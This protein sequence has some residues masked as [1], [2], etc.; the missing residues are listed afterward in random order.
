LTPEKRLLRKTIDCYTKN[1]LIKFQTQA[2]Y[3]LE[4]EV[5]RNISTHF[6]SEIPTSTSSI[7]KTCRK[8]FDS[9]ETKKPRLPPL[10]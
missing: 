6:S 1:Q 5:D 9:I 2:T 3:R 4:F 8:I 7:C 10:M